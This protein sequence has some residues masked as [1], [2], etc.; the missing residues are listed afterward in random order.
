MTV[1]KNSFHKSFP[2]NL[3]RVHTDSFREMCL[4]IGEKSFLKGHKEISNQS[5]EIKDCSIYSSSRTITPSIQKLIE[6]LEAVI[7]V[8]ELNYR[9]DSKRKLLLPQPANLE[10][11][12]KIEKLHHFWK[13]LVAWFKKPSYHFNIKYFHIAKTPP[14]RSTQ[15][16]SKSAVKCGDCKKVVKDDETSAIG[17]SSC[18]EWVHGS[19]AGLS[20]M[21]V[22]LLGTKS[23][24]VWLCDTCVNANKICATPKT[25]AKVTSIL[26][27]FSETW[28]QYVKPGDK[29]LQ[30]NFVR[31]DRKCNGGSVKVTSFLQWHC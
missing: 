7:F 21:E 5:N 29:A 23:N 2:R 11:D 14:L 8:H 31:H 28:I 15:L 10:C 30:R 16:H 27:I 20:D 12:S 17:C 1:P 6:K 19:C 13:R 22:I 26:D 18:G 9:D 25:E 4:K 24:V 3:D